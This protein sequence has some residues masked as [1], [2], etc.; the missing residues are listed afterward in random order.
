M[1]LYRP[2]SATRYSCSDMRPFRCL[3]W[4]LGGAILFFA[5]CHEIFFSPS[6]I[7]GKLALP[8]ST[9]AKSFYDRLVNGSSRETTFVCPLEPCHI[10][11][12]FMGDSITRFTYLSL[13]T[14]F[15]HNNTWY[16]DTMASPDIFQLEWYPKINNTYL[17][18]IEASQRLL[19]PFEV[20]CDCYRQKGA[21]WLQ[22]IV[23]NRY[24]YDPHRNITLTYIQTFGHHV[25]VWGH[26]DEPPNSAAKRQQ[27]TV[28]KDVDTYKAGKQTEPTPFN[29][30]DNLNWTYAIRTHVKAIQPDVLVLNAGYWKHY[31]LGDEEPARV[32]RQQLLQATLDAGIPTVLWKTTTPRV[33]GDR[34][35]VET[36]STDNTMCQLFKN[37]SSGSSG[38]LN[39]T[40]WTQWVP[41]EFYADGIHFLEPVYRKMN[42][43]L[44]DTLG[45]VWPGPH[46]QLLDNFIPKEDRPFNTRNESEIK[47]PVQL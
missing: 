15:A 31:F 44:L 5:I 46:D 38:C 45:I 24:Y 18:W 6:V 12:V 43:Q 30:T 16:N 21:T 1:R 3:I 11:I 2:T 29:W 10:N 32:L 9:Y 36:R 37:Y 23:E 17:P 20:E 22:H 8:A 35:P 34:Y 7:N 40:K 13:A 47:T 33:S 28:D 14:F 41:K 4:L 42:E 26:F 25:P 27:G 39:V 19:A